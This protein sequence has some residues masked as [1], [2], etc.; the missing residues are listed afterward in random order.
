MDIHSQTKKI[1]ELFK[2][3]PVLTTTE[4]AS[5]LK[6]SWNTAEK[7]MLELTIAGSV[8]RIKKAGVNLWIERRK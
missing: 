2:Q 7:L 8:T 3:S 6:V 4:I 5:K 1:A